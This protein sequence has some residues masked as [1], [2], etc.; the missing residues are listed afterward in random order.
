MKVVILAGGFGTRIADHSK[1]P[2][3]MISIN[4]KPIIAHILEIYI[5][6]KY[7][8]V[9]F[10]DPVLTRTRHRTALKKCFNFLKKVNNDKDPELNAEDIRLSLNSLGNITGKYD[11]EKLLDIVFKDFCIGK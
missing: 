2:K 7:K 5:K 8:D 6:H 4:G 1:M 3:P 9:F 11:V 10:G